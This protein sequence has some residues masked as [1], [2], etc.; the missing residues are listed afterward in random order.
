MVRYVG[1]RAQYERDI[2]QTKVRSWNQKQT[3]DLNAWMSQQILAMLLIML[4]LK[5][6]NIVRKAVSLN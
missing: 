4:S 1:I 3:G 2:A 5:K 6:D